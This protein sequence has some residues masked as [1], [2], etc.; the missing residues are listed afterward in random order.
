VPDALFTDLYELTMA[1]SYFAHG[2]DHEATFDLFVRTLPASRRFLVACGLDDALTYLEG[3][4]FT[5]D[6]LAFL[7][8]LGRFDAAFLDYLR[9]LRFTGDVWAVP[10][11][12]VVYANEPL[13]EVTGPLIVAQLVETYLLNTM[14]SQTMVASK[15]AR[16]ALACGDRPFVD[17]AARRTHGRDAARWGARA[18]VVG[19]ASGTSLVTAGRAFDLELSG[20]MAHSYVM[21]FAD[22]REAF[23]AYARDFPDGV[24]LLVDTYDTVE[25]AR[26]AAEV[27]RELA[28]EG[29]RVRA[30]R[31][32]S[33]DLLALSQEVRALLDEAGLENVGL[34]ASGDL[35]EHHILELLAAGAPIDGFGVGTQL[36]TSADAPYLAAVYKLVE[37]AAGPRIKLAPGKATL[38][39]RKQVFRLDDRDVVAERDEPFAGGRPLLEPVLRAGQRLAPSPA[40][41]DLRERCQRAVAALPSR[42]RTLHGR[43]VPWPVEVSPRLRALTEELTKAHS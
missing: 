43:E 6:D 37:D 25:G 35:D 20:T 33:G 26:H 38:P 40:V 9:E 12:E 42:L 1:A 18:S 3:L 17:F 14:A 24:V 11:G 13:L 22:E 4:R 7:S 39:G 23:C 19:G 10:E 32:D 28:P 2:L 16:V 41:G 15:A 34:F 5:D 8:S 27:A 21:S 30:L 29:I 36:G 31:L